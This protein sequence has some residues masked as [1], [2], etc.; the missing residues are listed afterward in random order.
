VHQS[1]DH[2]K[3]N[4]ELAV[5]FILQSNQFARPFSLRHD[6]IERREGC[7]QAN[8]TC[9]ALQTDLASGRWLAV[10]GRELNPLDSIEKFPSSTSDFLLPQIY[11]GATAKLP[12][13]LATYAISRNRRLAARVQCG[14]V[15]EACA[16]VCSTWI[17]IDSTPLISR[18][19]I[20]STARR[21]GMRPLRVQGI[22][23]VC[24]M[25]CLN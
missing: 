16:N 3:D 14:E 15:Q 23:C 5:I 25:S 22:P 1:T 17:S 9:G 19:I 2:V 13:V 4:L 24:A 6:R 18:R 10:A 20:R 21:A 7:F 8:D 12:Q 11:P